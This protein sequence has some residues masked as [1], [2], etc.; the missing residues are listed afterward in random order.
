[1]TNSAGTE[2]GG[3]DCGSNFV[4]YGTNG[5]NKISNIVAKEKKKSF[6]I[7]PSMLFHIRLIVLTAYYIISCGTTTWEEVFGRDSTRE[8]VYVTH[9]IL[10]YNYYVF[11]S[12][13]TQ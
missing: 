2:C 8:N 6:E 12:R 10:D 9:A 11:Y 7:F 3:C 5:V 1:M 13:F 4:S